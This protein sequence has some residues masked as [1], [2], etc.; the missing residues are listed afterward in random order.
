MK[1]IQ[2]PLQ[3][4]DETWGKILNGKAY[5]DGGVVRDDGGRIVEI[6]KEASLENGSSQVNNVVSNTSKI[7][8]STGQKVVIGTLVV[9]GAAAV[10]YGVYKLVGVIKKKK[11]KQQTDIIG[12][13][14]EITEYVNGVV[15]GQLSLGSIKK[16]II[17]FEMFGANDDVNIDIS[18]EEMKVLINLSKRYLEN[19][20]KINNIP[21]DSSLLI[22]SKSNTKEEA[23]EEMVLLLNKEKELFET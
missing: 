15:Q 14:P 4:S 19:I 12:Y 22:E 7:S 18:V 13:N 20:C 21:I 9:A 1:L 10:G 17:F 3:M 2:R 6:L 11:A 5:V 16:M 8:L 23:V